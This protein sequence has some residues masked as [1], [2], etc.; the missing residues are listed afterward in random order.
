M[1]ISP[2]YVK[3]ITSWPPIHAMATPLVATIV[4]GNLHLTSIMFRRQ[5]SYGSWCL[6]DFSYA[7]RYCLISAHHYLCI[8]HTVCAQSVGVPGWISRE[9]CYR[10][11][12]MFTPLITRV[13]NGYPLRIDTTCSIQTLEYTAPELVRD[14]ADGQKSFAHPSHDIW[15]LGCVAYFIMTGLGLWGSADGDEEIRL[16]LLDND[17][18]ILI[19]EY[20]VSNSQ[21]RVILQQLLEKEPRKR[22]TLHYLKVILSIPAK[23]H[24]TSREMC[25]L[26]SWHFCAKHVHLLQY[27]FSHITL[28]RNVSAN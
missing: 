21:T 18:A 27:A 6:S 28:V 2:Q 16:K 10:C 13:C 4:Y 17:D 7:C 8:L 5:R 11:Y 14:I 25:I 22:I 1:I 24:S 26:P 20:L 19:P 9:K 23:E 15:S 3:M 12:S